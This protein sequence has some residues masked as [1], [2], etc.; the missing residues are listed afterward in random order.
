MFYNYKNETVELASYKALCELFGDEST[1]KKI[2]FA[3]SK[4]IDIGDWRSEEP[5]TEY[6]VERHYGEIVLEP[7]SE[8]GVKESI[9]EFSSYYFYRYDPQ[10]NSLDELENSELI[11]SDLSFAINTVMES[12][13]WQDVYNYSTGVLYIETFNIKPNYRGKKFGYYIFP[14][15]VDAF[16]KRHNTIVVI[17]PKPITNMSKDLAGEDA[18]LRSTH[19]HQL[20]L[21]KMQNFIKQFGFEHIRDSELWVAAVMDKGGFEIPFYSNTN[22]GSVQEGSQ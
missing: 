20:A 3:E 16:S 9:G 17:N 13:R 10:G 22:F 19:E 7:Y 8:Y 14:V 6:G 11:S 21:T 18:T 2:Y 5:D 4:E 1:Y 12:K 15:L